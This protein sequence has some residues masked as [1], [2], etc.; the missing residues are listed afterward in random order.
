[1]IHSSP[2]RSALVLQAGEVGAGAGLAEELAADEVAPVHLAA[3]RRPWPRGC[4]GRGS[5]APPCRGRCRRSSGWAPRTGPRASGS[6]LV[7]GGG[8]GRGRR[9]RSGPVIQPRPASN[10]LARHA[11]ASASSAGLLARGRPP[12]TGRRRRS[13]RPRRSGLSSVSRL[14]VGLEEGGGLGAEL[15]ERDV[16]HVDPRVVRRDRSSGAGAHLTKR[17][18]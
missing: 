11:L 15:V 13:P 3:G 14:G 5:W 10:L 8:R 2:S 9:T 12:R 17:S 4:R 18:R 1:M 16:G 7:V 6:A